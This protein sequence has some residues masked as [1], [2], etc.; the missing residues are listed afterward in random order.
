[1]DIDRAQTILQAPETIKVTY[2]GTPVWI[3]EVEMSTKTA[4]VHSETNPDD[5]KVVEVNKLHEVHD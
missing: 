5:V 4:T 1:M 2:E 3:D